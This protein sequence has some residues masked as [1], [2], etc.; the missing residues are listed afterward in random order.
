MA[1]GTPDRAPAPPDRRWQGFLGQFHADLAARLIDRLS[2]QDRIG[3][4]EIDLLENA[5]RGDVA[6]GRWLEITP[7]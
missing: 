2:A 7:L 1:A 5:G 4:A 6:K 3:A